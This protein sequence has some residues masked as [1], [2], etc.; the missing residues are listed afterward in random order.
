[1][2]SIRGESRGEI[3]TDGSVTVASQ[4]RLAAQDQ[5]ITELGLDYSHTGILRSDEAKQRMNALLDEYVD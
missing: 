1:M 5:A 3:S 2:F 4:L